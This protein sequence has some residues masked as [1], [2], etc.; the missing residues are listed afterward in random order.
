M[1]HELQRVTKLDEKEVA[2]QEV[3]A[4]RE[5]FVNAVQHLETNL[6]WL[7]L[8]ERLTESVRR[9]PLQWVASAALVGAVLGVLSEKGKRR[10]DGSESE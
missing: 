9:Y 8:P 6:Q 2:Q 7:R 10:D 4:A 5:T 1:R 3:E